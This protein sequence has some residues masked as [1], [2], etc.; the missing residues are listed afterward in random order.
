ML[1]T[2]YILLGTLYI[3]LGTLSQENIECLGAAI[4]CRVTTEDPE[5]NFVPGNGRIIT[6]R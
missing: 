6:Y 4:Q 2:L 5:N 3:L 1:G